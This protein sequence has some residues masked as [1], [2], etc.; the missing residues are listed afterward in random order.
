MDTTTTTVGDRIKARRTAIGISQREL[1]IRAGLAQ[2][3]ISSLEQNIASNSRS[4]ALIAQAL[5]VS[6]LWLQTGE[7]EPTEA[8]TGTRE[9]ATLERSL[10]AIENLPMPFEVEI[11][12]SRGSCGGGSTDQRDVDEIA[13]TKRAF[14]LSSD[15]Q[16]KGV[17]DHTAIKAAIADGN[18]MANFL[19]HGDLV[20]F[21][22]SN[23]RLLTNN[24]YAFETP[25][26]LLIKRVLLRSNGRIVL[27]SDNPDKQRYPDEDLAPEDVKVIGRFF[28]LRR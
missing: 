11:L 6:A 1:A 16:E 24:I 13:A 15:L 25:T 8:M 28:L 4:L 12:D 7:G 5:G 22:T 23:T 21:D 9:A 18:G 20:L 14:V 19:V 3:T 17:T 2:P 26:G 27:T 10:Y